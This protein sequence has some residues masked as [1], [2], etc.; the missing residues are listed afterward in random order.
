MAVKCYIIGQVE[1]Y[2]GVGVDGDNELMQ[3]GKLQ[4]R[5][6]LVQLGDIDTFEMDSTLYL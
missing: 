3:M 4:L 5:K 1:I 2:T 6:K